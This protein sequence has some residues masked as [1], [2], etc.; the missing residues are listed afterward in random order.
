MNV[1][2]KNHQ[3]LY[4]RHKLYSFIIN[5]QNL[6]IIWGV[7]QQEFVK[8]ADENGASRF[9][10]RWMYYYPSLYYITLMNV[11]LFLIASPGVVSRIIRGEFWGIIMKFPLLIVPASC[12]YE[13]KS[14][15]S[16]TPIGKAFPNSESVLGHY[17]RF[18]SNE[19][20]S[21]T[22]LNPLF[23]LHSLTIKGTIE[24]S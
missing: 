18:A 9:S 2:C 14:I 20:P 7:P 19:S 21:M 3:R 17:L 5:S 15:G 1:T 10:G 4:Q 24:L 6:S 23:V 13:W 8:T 12:H 22:M 11:P 16:E